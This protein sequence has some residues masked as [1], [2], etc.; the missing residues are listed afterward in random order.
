M[1]T[2]TLSLPDASPGTRHSLVRHLWGEAKRGPRVHLQAGLHADEMPG[3]LVLWHLMEMLD[4]AEAEGRLT[5]RVAVVPMANPI[6]LGQWLNGKPQG[7]RDLD[8]GGNFNRGYPDLARLAGD[9]LDGRLGADPGANLAAIRAAFA[10]ALDA[11]HPATPLEALRQALLRW[12]IQADIVLDLHC[13]HVALM[14]FYTSSARPE[15]A[16]ALGRATGSVLALMEETSG[17]HAFD[18]A[19]TAPWRALRARFPQA[20]IPDPVFAATVEYRGQQDVADGQARQ[21]ALNLMAFLGAVGVV[22]GAP[23]LAHP[24]ARALP[25]SG[26][27]EA[28]APQGGIVTWAVDPGAS[29]TRGDP[30]AWVSDPMTRRRLAVAAPATGLLFRRELWPACL[31][32]Q[33]LAHVAGD[34]PIRQGDLLSD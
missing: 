16:E 15:V 8:S 30:I 26:T 6:G 10:Q 33:S 4:A 18:E 11:L 2:E 22:R 31:R 19:Q 23:A 14:H 17:G 12:S 34:V 9:A 5:G 32:G 27:G 7:R 20:A 24:P 3:P 29:V 13:D 25:L 21:D 1:R 28:F